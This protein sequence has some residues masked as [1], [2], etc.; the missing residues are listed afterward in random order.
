MLPRAYVAYGLWFLLSSN[1]VSVSAQEANLARRSD[2]VIHVSVERVNVGVTVTGPR[3]NFVTGLQRQ[4]FQIFDNGEEQ[5]LTGFLSIEEPG[6]VV[7]LME[8][9]PAALFLKKSVLQ[10]ADTFLNSVSPA[11]RVALVTYSNEPQVVLDFT[12]NK[13]EVRAALHGMNFMAGFGALNLA[14]SVATILDWLAVVPG[15]KT[16]V[17]LSSGVDTS[18][19]ANW[20]T[21]QQKIKISDVRIVAVS[22]VTDLRK[23]AKKKHLSTD[24]RDAHKYLK[25][26]FAQADQS[27]R[28]L[29]EATGGRVYFP[30]NAKG[31][32]RNYAE[33]AQLLRHEY[34]LEFVP[35]SRDGRLHTLEIKVKHSWYHVQNRQSYLAPGPTS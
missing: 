30:K 32:E 34:S 24:E 22:V 10:A 16:I 28:E 5:P 12:A 18:P 4:D 19:V 2:G 9:G 35:P 31:F 1:A 26:G 27:L 17:L 7:L 33:I 25:E 13:S 29:S 21:I 14:S 11:D 20:Q 8:C 3:G 23:P 6:Q 15:K